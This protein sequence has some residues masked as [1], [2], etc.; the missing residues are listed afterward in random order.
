M[1]RHHEFLRRD[2]IT[3]L[4]KMKIRKP[5]EMCEAIPAH[6]H[7]FLFPFLLK[8]LFIFKGSS[9]IINFKA[10][11]L[12]PVAFLYSKR[13]TSWVNWRLSLTSKTSVRSSV[14][15]ARAVDRHTS[16][17]RVSVSG[18]SQALAAPISATW[19]TN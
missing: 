17:K 10:A 15:C 18:P 16:G 7:I 1:T 5:N 4:F 12:R 13:R 9:A 8:L 2:D 19:L 14:R 11:T 6:F 3:I